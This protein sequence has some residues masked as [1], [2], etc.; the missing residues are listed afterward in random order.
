MTAL[1]MGRKKGNGRTYSDSKDERAPA[2]RI[3]FILDCMFSS[4]STSQVVAEWQ[5]RHSFVSVMRVAWCD[6]PYTE[7]QEQTSRTSIEKTISNRDVESSA[8][9]TSDTNELDVTRLQTAMSSIFA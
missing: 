2:I 1:H 6:L 8:D 4:F 9:G 3:K 5:F 7:C